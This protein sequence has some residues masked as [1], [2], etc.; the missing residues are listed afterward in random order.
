MLAVCL[1]DL[2][3]EVKAGLDRARRIGFRGVDVGAA[4]GPVSPD[5]LSA[6]GRR[7]LV[8]H[9]EDLGLSL[10]SLRGP[11]GGKGFLEPGAGERRLET[12]RKIIPLA[13]SLKTP[14]V[15]TAPGP[16]AH[17][18]DADRLREVLLTLADDAD[19]TGVIVAVENSGIASA[20]LQRILAEINCPNL[21][22]C[23]D[24]GA[25]ILQG[26]DPNAVASLMPGR[27]RLVRL[28]DAVPGG[29]ER[30]GEE[31]RLGDGALDPER[32][33]A[34]LAESGFNRDL[35]LSRTASADPV[36]D[37]SHARTLLAPLVT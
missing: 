7:H 23:C 13:R 16:I 2:K 6:T 28:R 35:I 36:A 19:R 25:M 18:R 22:A 8:K 11:A 27:I 33:L 20:T 21:A 30:S 9:L 3:L 1:D 5:E 26:E 4:A 31:K 15:S 34:A 14:V 12:M 10:V 37:L 32:F 24:S 17:D 29:A